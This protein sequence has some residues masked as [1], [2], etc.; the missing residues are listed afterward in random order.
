MRVQGKRLIVFFDGECLLCS[1]LVR[2]CHSVDQRQRLWFAALEGEYAASCR[3]ELALS[4][5]GGN[6]DSFAFY[7]E[8][9]E[10][11][12]FRSDGVVALLRSLDGVWPLLGMLLSC[13]PRGLRDKGY[14]LIARNRRFLFTSSATCSLPSE[15]LR[16]RILG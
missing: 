14:D 3:E 1:R 5:A 7:Q 13:F 12:L 11:V 15:S 9:E 16:G 8:E 10:L 4:E 6:A 2:W